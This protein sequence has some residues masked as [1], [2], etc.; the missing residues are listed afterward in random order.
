MSE[1][2]EVARAQAPGIGGPVDLAGIPRYRKQRT[3]TTFTLLAVMI[4]VVMSAAEG[5]LAWPAEFPLRRWLPPNGMVMQGY[6]C[7]I[8]ALNIPAG[9]RTENRLVYLAAA[10]SAGLGVAMA[11]G[12]AALFLV[13][14]PASP[15]GWRIAIPFLAGIAAA[16]AVTAPM[17]FLA[18]R[19]RKRLEAGGAEEAEA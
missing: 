4:A 18:E 10:L 16:V 14:D 19:R 5:W 3:V 9:N 1:R 7:T 17:T 2:P 8:L 12:C 13:L 15:P 6:M 11:A